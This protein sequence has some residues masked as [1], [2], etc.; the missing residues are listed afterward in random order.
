MATVKLSKRGT[1]YLSTIMAELGFR[2][3]PGKDNDRP[4]ALRLAFAKG[5]TADTLPNEETG[6]GPKEFEFNTNVITK[7]NS[8]LLK[9][10]IINKLQRKISDKE[11]NKYV[12]LF[13]E[14]G[15]EI[16]YKEIQ[17]LTNMDNYMI[18]LFDKHTRMIN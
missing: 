2:N 5:I 15:L 8:I 6:K 9:H 10:L 13:V 17:G 3:T 1:E 14:H 7:G 11:F 12:L 18:Y 4:T 16:M